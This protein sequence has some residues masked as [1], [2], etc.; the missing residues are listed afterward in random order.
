[1]ICRWVA[2]ISRL[3]KIMG[4]FCRVLSLLW[5]SFAKETYNFKEPAICSHTIA[6]ASRVAPAA[7][8]GVLD[9]EY[10]FA[11]HRVYVCVCVF[12]ARSLWLAL[13][14]GSFYVTYTSFQL[15]HPV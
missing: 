7:L 2:T 12:A 13:L 5:G 8:P 10:N 4:L 9:G 6:I 15:A 11:L 3:L 1:M 14:I